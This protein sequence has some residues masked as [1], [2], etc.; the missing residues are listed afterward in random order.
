MSHIVSPSFQAE[1]F[2]V[3]QK[4]SQYEIHMLIYLSYMEE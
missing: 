2:L 4:I 1:I 3:V